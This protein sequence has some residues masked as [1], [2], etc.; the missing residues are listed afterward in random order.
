MPTKKQSIILMFAL[1]W[2]TSCSTAQTGSDAPAFGQ[3]QSGFTL[4]N[5]TTI[6]GVVVGAPGGGIGSVIGLGGVSEIRV[7]TDQETLPVQLAPQAYLDT[8][9]TK[10]A[11]GDMVEVDGSRVIQNNRPVIIATQVRRGNQVLNLR[12]P[13]GKPLWLSQPQG[14]AA[15]QGSPGGM[16]GTAGQ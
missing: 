15:S 7:K 12:D 9:N 8:Q 13:Q 1:V 10:L 3:D 4:Q 16:S 11:Q 6:R 5:I 2:I 14:G